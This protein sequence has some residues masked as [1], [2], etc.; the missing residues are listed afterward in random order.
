MIECAEATGRELVAQIGAGVTW[1]DRTQGV[2]GADLWRHGHRLDYRQ[3]HPPRAVLVEAERSC[4]QG[5]DDGP[6]H[7]RIAIPIEAF[8]ALIRMMQLAMDLAAQEGDR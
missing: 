8:P 5:D 4:W 6:D 2:C 7:Q 1:Q 3:I